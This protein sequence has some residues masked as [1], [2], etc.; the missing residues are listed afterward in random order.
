MK[1]W[2]LDG[3]LRHRASG[4]QSLIPGTSSGRDIFSHRLVF[5]LALGESVLDHVADRHQA[6]EPLIP[7]DR[8]MARAFVGHFFHGHMD[9]FILT[10]CDHLGGHLH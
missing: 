5:I 8:E 4:R 3:S 7:D 2:M 1:A 6:D 9:A 10:R